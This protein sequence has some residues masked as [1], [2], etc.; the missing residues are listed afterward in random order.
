ML[1]GYSKEFQDL[2]LA[3]R[4]IGSNS[5]C[6]YLLSIGLPIITTFLG[7]FVG[8]ILSRSSERKNF[9]REMYYKI[10]NTIIEYLSFFNDLIIFINN[11]QEEGIKNFSDKFNSFLIIKE[12]DYYSIANKMFSYKKFL[13]SDPENKKMGGSEDLGY[14]KLQLKMIARLLDYE[15]FVREGEKFGKTMMLYTE[16]VDK[17]TKDEF[18]SL[19]DELSR[20]TSMNMREF[21]ITNYY[22]KII[23]YKK[24]VSNNLKKIS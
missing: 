6:Q 23:N 9:K 1:R 2:I 18:Q 4:E 16:L 20:F 17:N 15:I 12:D 19:L 7:I 14:Y 3:I 10:L 8:V 21:Y 24:K 5:F 13:E 22:N 11:L